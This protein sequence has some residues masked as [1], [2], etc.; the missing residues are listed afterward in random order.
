MNIK[1]IFCPSCGRFLARMQGVT[2]GTVAV[3]CRH[4]KVF[5]AHKAEDGTTKS[6]VAP[7]PVPASREVQPS[8]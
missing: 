7:P 4:C 1:D 3:R 8:A 5:A 6:V 2:Q